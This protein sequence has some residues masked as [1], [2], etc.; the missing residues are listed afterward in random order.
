VF[1]SSDEREAALA[2]PRALA[3]AR[4]IVMEDGV[5]DAEA[6][7]RAVR[8]VVET[9]RRRVSGHARLI[10]DYVSESD[11]RTLEELETIDRPALILLA[12]RVGATRLIDNTIVLPKGLPIP[13]ELRSLFDSNAATLPR[14]DLLLLTSSYPAPTHTNCLSRQY[15]RNPSLW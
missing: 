9:P 11:E 3:V 13:Q 1:L 5:T 12:A 7:G 15:S 4:R 8:D 6:I 10:L 2:L 14:S